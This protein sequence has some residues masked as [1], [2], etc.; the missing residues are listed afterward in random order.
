M[1]THKLFK[2]NAK[3]MEWNLLAALAYSESSFTSDVRSRAGALGLMGF[4][5]TTWSHWAPDGA[6]PMEPDWA[7]RTA[8]SY[9]K[10]L[11]DNTDTLYEALAA[12][13]WGIGNVKE[14]GVKRAPDIVRQRANEILYAS[15][16]IKAWENL[17]HE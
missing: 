13:M 1:I 16:A 12:Y 2:E 7:V 5:P 10:W 3:H 9:L 6:S 17:D 11:E 15:R 4:M 14:L 8:D